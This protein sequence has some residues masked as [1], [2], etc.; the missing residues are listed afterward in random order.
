MKSLVVFCLLALISSSLSKQIK[1]DGLAP[2]KHEL[3]RLPV[4]TASEVGQDVILTCGITNPGEQHSLLW[5]E[6]AQTSTGGLISSNDLVL[7]PNG[8]RYHIIHDD[9]AQ[10]DLQISSVDFG[11][12]GIYMCIET[13]TS[14]VD[15]RQHSASLTVIATEPNCTTTIRESGTVLENSYNTNDCTLDYRGGLIP[16]ISW[17]G[18]GPF[19]SLYVTTESSV[20]GGMAFNASRNMDNRFHSANIYFTDYFLPVDPNTANNI[21][22]YQKGY[23]GRLM[24]VRWGPSV[25][26]A[27]PIKPTYDVGDFI[28][29]TADANP[30]ANYTWFN[31][32][33]LDVIPGDEVRIEEA[34]QGQTFILRC[35]AR[36]E[37]EGT[38]YPQNLFLNVT[39]NAITEPTTPTTTPS[40]TTVPPVS[41][42][43]DLTGAWESLSPTTGA[44]CF[45]LDLNNNGYLTGL[46][47]NASDTYWIDIVGRAQSNRFDQVG[48]SGI[49]PYDIGVSSFVGECHRCFGEEQ[50][51]MNLVSRTV[52]TECG[53]KGETRYTSQYLFTRTNQIACNVFPS[54]K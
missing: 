19:N 16:N 24:L 40:T 18:I 38:V 51:L 1:S 13:Y 42:C 43:G 50:L 8:D 39:V 7:H 11:D 21:P 3:T 6:F 9:P 25:P 44:L 47:R 32:Q 10:Y 30:A 22:E 29:C 35:E 28:K 23:D 53:V 45:R 15:K 41:D 33:T 49:W 12:G 4:N 37:I 52:G 36:N 17:S 14:T 54:L 34:W 27:T 46:M 26:E 20:W 5:Y 48:F 2:S 31:L